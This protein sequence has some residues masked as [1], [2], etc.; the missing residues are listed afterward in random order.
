V[1]RAVIEMAREYILHQTENYRSV[2]ESLQA[3][4][5]M[6]YD[7]FNAY[8]KARS[9]TLV[10]TPNPALNQAVMKEED[11][12]DWKIAEEML[13]AWLGLQSEVGH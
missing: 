2:I 6:T 9:E 4:Y 13:Q 12:S 8:L 5:G 11:A 1:E 3:K 10:K 7:Q